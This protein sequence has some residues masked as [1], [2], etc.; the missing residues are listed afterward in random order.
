MADGSVTIETKIDDSGAKKGLG[1]LSSTLGKVGSGIISTFKVGATAIAGVSTAFAGLVTASVNARGEL[2]QQIGGIETLFTNELGSASETVIK[3]AN[4]A[5]KTAG[6]SAIDYMSTATSFSASLLQSLGNDTKKAAEVTDMAI[7]D[8]SDNANKMGTS[9]ESIQWAYQGFAKQ[10]YTMLDNLKLGY[11][12]TKTEMERLLKDAQ[13]ITGIKYDISNLSDVYNAIHVIQGELGITGTTAK[14]AS[15]TLQ[16][17]FSSMKAAWNNFL[18]GSGNLGQVADTLTDVVKNIVRLLNEAIPQIM[19]SISSALPELLT[20]GGEILNQIMIGIT[21]Y[22]PQ[23]MGTAGQVLNSLIQGIITYLPQIIPVAMQVI[24]QLITGI[25]TYLPQ[26]MPAVVQIVQQIITILVECL[27]QILLMGEEIIIQLIAGIAQMLPELIPQALNCI[28]TLVNGIIENLDLIADTGVELIIGLAEGLINAIPQL[29]DKIPIIIQKLKQVIIKNL[30]KIIEM[31]I[32]LLVELGAG[33]I[34]AIPQLIAM[35][36]QIIGAIINAFFETDWGEIGKQL[37][38]G[39][40]N[41]FS[42]AG[43]IIWSAIKKVGNSMI[44]GIKS[45][46]GI[47]SPSKVFA[48]LGKYLPQGFAE[49]IDKDS[50]QAVKSANKMNESILKG[51]NFDG[52]YSKMQ[53]AV[54]LE[55]GKIATNLSIT[56]AIDRVLTANI[57]MQPGDIYMDSSKVGRLVAPSVSKTL[58]T[59]GAY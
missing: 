54:N 27:P 51:F 14:E 40:L 11:G 38:Q 5:Y 47:H 1:T 12:G 55:T 44:S 52:L 45:F 6:M 35:I 25:I 56:S 32:R 43:N 39:L 59:G 9:M 28:L 48:D 34:A 19:E 29:I 46:F 26:L 36:P 15:E 24:Q 42:N 21:T 50:K 53:N 22:L 7:T 18:S 30:P 49:G 41:G 10:N 23:L 58:R 13:K 31:G 57:K 33:L 3:N 16:G 2:E 17:S 37:L 20:L 4:N 8:M